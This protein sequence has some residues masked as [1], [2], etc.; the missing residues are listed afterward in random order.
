MT[1]TVSTAVTE[2]S[3][4]LRRLAGRIT[5]IQAQ[6]DELLTE[7]DNMI[8]DLLLGK[9]MTGDEIGAVL[10]MSQPHT[11]QIK[12]AVIKQRKDAEIQAKRDAANKR[13]RDRRHAQKE[14][15][16]HVAVETAA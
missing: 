15:T 5:R 10:N 11:A 14:A 9:L 1:T 13:R 8:A 4:A 7:R 12:A 6:M 2:E 16:G 3:R